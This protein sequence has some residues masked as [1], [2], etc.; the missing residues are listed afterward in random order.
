MYHILPDIH[1]QADKLDV[2]LRALGWSRRAGGWVCDDPNARIVFLGDF[3]DRGPDQGR[4]LATVRSLRDAGKAMAVMGNH[5]LN[6]VQYH[7]DGPQGPLRPRTDKNTCQHAAFLR[8]FPLG[9]ARAA[10]AIRW[11]TTLALWIETDTLR[12]VHACWHGPT[13]A[14]LGER[15]PQARLTEAAIHAAAR[16]PDLFA[17]LERITKGPEHPLPN[18]LGFHDKGGHWR[19]EARI[20]WW[21]GQ[22]GTWNRLGETGNPDA[23]LPA[24]PAPD[25]ALRYRYTDDMPVFF[26]HYWLTGTPRLESDRALC[27]DYSAGAGGP[28][29]AYRH[30][31]RATRL[32]AANLSIVAPA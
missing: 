11:M 9:S 8:E 21:R 1:G 20:A 31:R 14:R 19:T 7:T 3:I 15:L 28:L 32:D 25:T 16:D 23:I 22:A 4:V 2:G 6:A 18:G 30:P 27:L 17:D 10:E 24:D 12:A 26:G 13:I 5:E 29:V